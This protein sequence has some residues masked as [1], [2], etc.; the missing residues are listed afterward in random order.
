MVKISTF[1]ILAGVIAFLLEIS[2]IVLIS[3]INTTGFDILRLPLSI[4]IL[5]MAIFTLF[6]TISLSYLLA[7]K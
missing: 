5:G 6:V 1:V 4:L 3:N 2:S 7:N